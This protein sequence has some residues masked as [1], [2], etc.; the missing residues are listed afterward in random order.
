LV[1]PPDSGFDRELLPR[2]RWRVSL[3][4][5][6]GS[7]LVERE[8]QLRTLRE[9][10]TDPP[11]A[12][13]VALLS[14]EA[15]YGKTS[16]LNSLIG[17]L[18]HRHRVL[19]ATC[20]P[21]GIPAAFSPLFE[22]LEEM[23][24]DVQGDLMSGVG[25]MGVYNGMLD[26]LKNDRVLFVL[27]DLHWADEATL[28]L[29]RYLGRRIGS[30]N[31]RLIL[32]YRSEEL[33][34]NPPLRLVVADLGPRA[35]RVDL[36]ALTLSGVEE[37]VQNR[38]LD[39]ASIYEATSGSPFFVEEVIQSPDVELPPTVHNAI[40]TSASRLPGEA[41]EFLRLVALS[42]DGIPLDTVDELGD[43]QGGFSDLA[44]QKRLLVSPP[45]RIDCRHELVRRSLVH[46][47]TPALKRRLHRKLLEMLEKR[48]TDSSDIARLAYHSI[49]A[50]D[51][52]RASRYSMQAASDAAKAGAHREA[53]FH[54]ANALEFHD[55]MDRELHYQ[56]LLAAAVEHN[57][58]NAFDTARD[59][60][61][62]RLELADSG[63]EMARSHAWIAFFESRRN[64]LPAARRAA[65]K[66][67]D[68]LREHELYPE[69]PLALAVLA[70]VE[71]V[72]GNWEEAV[73]LGHE[74]VALARATHSPGFEVYA[75]STA[76]TARWLLGD[77]SGM[78]EVEEAVRLG[79]DSDAGEFAAKAM[80]NIGVMCLHRGD[81]EGARRW[82]D[83]LQDYTTTHE[84]DAWYIAAVSTMAWINVV[85][86]RWDDADDDL[87][88]IT[89][90][91]TCFQT[92]IETLITSAT[93]R[94]RRA[95]PGAVEQA[96]E[97]FGRLDG[98]DDHDLQVMGCVLAM[99]A[100]WAGAIPLA[101]AMNRYQAI[102]DSKVLER[103]PSGQAVL[104]FWALRLGV[105]PPRGHL[106]GAAGREQRGELAEATS[107]WERMGFPVEAAITQAILPG[108]DLNAVFAGLKARG[109]EGVA[110]GLRRELQRRGVKRIPRGERASTR[111]SPAGLTERETQV[112]GL[113]GTGNSNAAIAE[114]LFIS[115][116]TAG[117][118]V[119]SVLS[120]LGVSSRGQ[121]A[122]V[123]LANGWT[124]APAK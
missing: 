2:Y 53:A 70:W 113:L 89:G 64:D 34:Q 90:Q 1:T 58:V 4:T 49:G 98:F 55:Q 21:L 39:A 103:D 80:N 43:A 97:V 20:E 102:Q 123:A 101:D 68:A 93:L 22:L 62:R 81:L 66:A 9:M 85:S 88:A 94:V 12:R 45:G 50:A 69:L 30:T 71:Q 73:A 60:A 19:M 14:G 122:A 118:H 18:D 3:D 44:F 5:V 13:G 15:G 46:S 28:G 37:M 104:R 117:H 84:L 38:D 16:L 59:L 27:E 108:A 115:E 114:E 112:L 107:R 82:F 40:L 92:E 67:V 25:R 31:S 51:R 33:D 116:K 100:A 72:A 120:K 6:I 95:D 61:R 78:A 29:A 110:R 10:F 36:P 76:G 86:G 105:D 99:E 56:T 8:Q 83:Q 54:Y 47:T 11:S 77:G 42:P 63:T 109:A 74:G 17:E 48:A 124:E 87:E 79:I 24:P 75:A 26:V 32:T 106:G 23:P 57:F 35:V 7:G 52:M 96:S 119:S 91:K 111:S 41:L 121:A 65:G